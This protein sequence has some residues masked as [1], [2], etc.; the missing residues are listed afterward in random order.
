MFNLPFMGTKSKQPARR[1]SVIGLLRS[2]TIASTSRLL[3]PWKWDGGFSNREVKA[4]LSRAR[5]RARDMF[6]NSAHMRRYI[7]LCQT[8]IVGQGFNFKSMPHDGFPGSDNYRL[9]KVAA[10]FI[11][12]HWNRWAQ[13]RNWVDSTGR[14]NLKAIDKLNIK[15]WKRD[16]EY[17][18]LIDNSAQNPY[19]ISLRVIRPDAIP[20]NY[21]T[22]LRNG[23]LVR[24]GVE[25]DAVTMRPVA[26][27]ISTTKEFEDIYFAGGSLKRYPAE[28][29]IHG[30][31]QEDEDQTRGIPSVHAVLAKLKML[32]E[33]DIAELTV[34]R[35]EA[36]TSRTY[37]APRNRESEIVD[38]TDPDDAAANVVRERMQAPSEPGQKEILPE[39]WDS[40]VQ[41]PQHPNR[42]VTGF[43][44]SMLRDVAGGVNLE[45]ANFANDWQGVNYSS[46]RAGTISER[47]SWKSDQDDYILQCKSPVFLAWL[48][49]FLQLR[50][51]G[52]FPLA[53]YN[54]FAEHVFRGRRWEWVDP[55]KDMRA[56]ET[57]VKHGWKTDSE[58]AAELSNDYDRNIEE[59]KRLDGIK[60]GTSLEV[61]E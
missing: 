34:A 26:Y 61:S 22:T 53:K 28:L 8:N 46:V 49:S 21:N 3:A 13:N 27:Y 33:F 35:D 7:Y 55:L 30:Y 47:D 20:H 16:G 23:N 58:I 36:N 4:A 14:K 57:A 5:S 9:D 18:M 1:K 32:D 24:M 45:Y 41:V 39:G 31:T 48:W 2:F 15:S 6:K 11:E 38:L 37:Y 29:I 56:N 17:F 51:S 25:L 19:G 54:K 44:N 42:E 52:E 59:V 50:I 10:A 60:K 43:K 12:F 40:K